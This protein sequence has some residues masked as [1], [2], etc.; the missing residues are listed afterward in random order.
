MWVHVAG[1]ADASLGSWGGRTFALFTD[2]ND[3]EFVGS[4]KKAVE[5]MGFHFVHGDASLRSL[6]GNDAEDNYR[7]F[8][9]GGSVQ[10][11]ASLRLFLTPS[12]GVSCGGNTM[13][14]FPHFPY[15]LMGP[16]GMRNRLL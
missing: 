13:Q 1:A 10:D 4:I 16:V 7:V 8:S 5:N 3:K 2:D 15:S 12:S 6:F 9:A 14:P 11:F